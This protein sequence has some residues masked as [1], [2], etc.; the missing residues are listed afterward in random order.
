MNSKKIFSFIYVKSG[1]KITLKET[2]TF[3]R[4]QLIYNSKGWN[5]LSQ[6]FIK[7]INKF[8]S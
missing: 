6:T 8:L 4:S 2:V 1:S 3:K 7:N 5:P